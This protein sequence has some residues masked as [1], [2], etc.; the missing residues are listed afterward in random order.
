M[1]KL[2]KYA[3][4]QSTGK[5]VYV[6]DV[7]KGKAC[8]CFCEKCNSQVEA[9]QGQRNQWHFRHVKESGC[10]GSQ[11]TAIHRLAKQIII[12]NFEMAIPDEL[13][14]YADANQEQ[15]F[16]TIRPDI[17]A[18]S[19][20]NNVFIEVRVTHAIEESTELFYTN[21]KHNC[22][23]IDL[24]KIPYDVSPEDLTKLILKESKNKRKVYWQTPKQAPVE[25]QN[26]GLLIAIC[27][28]ILT[29]LF[30]SFKSGQRPNLK[31]QG[32]R[33]R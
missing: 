4:E 9:V 27:L 13:L 1:S 24:R 16:Q 22:I 21:G 15:I 26:Y 2:I 6:N 7:K 11:E 17:I 5:P 10:P 23:E 18:V 12:E 14:M 8:D 31:L 32:R 30:Y 20:D 3:L 33:R 19:N 25:S 28:F 29:L